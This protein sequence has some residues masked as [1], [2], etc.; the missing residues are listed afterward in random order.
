MGA[1]A[2]RDGV[3]LIADDA[4]GALW[5]STLAQGVWRLPAVSGPP[6][7][8]WAGRWTVYPEPPERGIE[9]IAILSDRDGA[10]WIGTQNAGLLRRLAGR[11]GS[12]RPP[13][14]W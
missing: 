12:R 14:R 4:E 7:G 2:G 6:S 11:T 8:P 1:L 10:L 5:V 13:R 9:S 3:F